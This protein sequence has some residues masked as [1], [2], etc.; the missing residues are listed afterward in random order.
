MVSSHNTCEVIDTYI[1]DT[2]CNDANSTDK[3]I[4]SYIPWSHTPTARSRTSSNHLCEYIQSLHHTCRWRIRSSFD[5]IVE[6]LYRIRK[7]TK[8][9]KTQGK[10]GNEING[11]SNVVVKGRFHILFVHTTNILYYYTAI[12]YSLAMFVCSICACKWCVSARIRIHFF[13]WHIVHWQYCFII[14]TF[15]SY[16]RSWNC[17]ITLESRI[18]VRICFYLHSSEII[19]RR[20]ADIGSADWSRAVF[21]VPSFT[22]HL[23]M[24]L[25]ATPWAFVYIRRR[26][27]GVLFRV[28]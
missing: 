27:C 26:H 21:L 9:K 13:F 7:A 20:T 10:L 2:W 19:H 25:A 8:K 22:T 14:V 6:L 4:S 18:Y 1:D 3:I 28:Q 15:V 17:A 11:S 23:L 5:R 24:T 16:I 12:F